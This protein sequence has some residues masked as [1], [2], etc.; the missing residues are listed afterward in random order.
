MSK[1]FDIFE[2][3]QENSKNELISQFSDLLHS[4]L[5]EMLTKFDRLLSRKTNNPERSIINLDEFKR[6]T[7]KDT[8]AESLNKNLA[9]S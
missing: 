7:S 3:Q 1:I 9:N 2:A 6:L 5:T 8:L 4:V